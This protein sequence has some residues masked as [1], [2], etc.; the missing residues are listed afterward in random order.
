MPLSTHSRTQEWLIYG[1]S[2]W[3]QSTKFLCSHCSQ[4]KISVGSCFNT[5]RRQ[6]MYAQSLSWASFPHDKMSNSWHPELINYS[7]SSSNYYNCF[8]F[9]T[10]HFGEKQNSSNIPHTMSRSN[11]SLILASSLRQIQKKAKRRRAGDHATLL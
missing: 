3:A 4:L 6:T 7:S 1:L 5:E 2:R 8:S 11:G 9:L 10:N